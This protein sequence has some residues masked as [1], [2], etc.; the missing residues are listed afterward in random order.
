MRAW[1]IVLSAIVALA[2]P[3]SS[4][5]VGESGADWTSY[6]NGYSGH[7]FSALSQ[8]T[9]ANAHALHKVCS[10]ELGELGPFQAS[11]VVVEGTLFV[12][13]AHETVALNAATCAVVWL[14]KHKKEGPEPWNTNRGVAVAGDRVIRGHQDGHLVAY[15]RKTGKVLWD[16]AV[17]SGK[18]GEF[19]AAAPLVWNDTVFMGAAGSDW[20]IKGRMM[21]FDL[22][23]GK[24]KWTFT[25]IASGA[26]PHANSWTVK[27]AVTGGGG[28]WTTYTLDPET[29]ELFVPVGNPAPDF[30]SAYR[31]GSNLYTDSLVV[32][33][34][35]TGKLKWY[36]QTISHDYHDW[37]LASAPVLYTRADGTKVVSVASK[38]GYVYAIDRATHELAFKTPGERF[39]NY[40]AP[41]TIKGTRFCPGP[42]GGAEWNGSAFDEN[43]RLLLTPMDDWCT[44]VKLGIARYSEGQFF[45]GGVYELDPRPKAG[46]TLSAIDAETG[47]VAWMYRSPS[48]MLAGVTP[49]AGGVT[50]TGDLDGNFLVFDTTSGKVLFKDKEPSG[51]VAGGVV[52]YAVEGKQYVGLTSGNVSR[53]FWGISGKPSIVVYAL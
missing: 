51:A 27:S 23:T 17:T 45:M 40:D 39:V 36:Y 1:K 20:G 7:R 26:D 42:L 35:A 3:T 19:L 46:G 49:T 24:K 16:V 8:I 22:A 30:A 44:T 29:G 21:A 43:H 32:L 12:T 10:R 28:T 5:A 38:D 48:P 4:L 15:D 11:P 2:I 31:P 47:K 52:S 41:L 9:P 33:D 34:A 37:D 18:S 50:F 14:D 25:T 6:N 13:T 53:A